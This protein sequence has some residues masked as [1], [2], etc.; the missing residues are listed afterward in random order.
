M[1]IHGADSVSHFHTERAIM[2]IMMLMLLL[3][4]FLLSICTSTATPIPLTIVPTKDPKMLAAELDAIVQKNNQDGIFDGAILVA[5]KCF[6]NPRRSPINLVNC[7]ATPTR[8]STYLERL[9]TIVI[10]H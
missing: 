10:G 6:R 5:Q 7:L 3:A 4:V 8:A 1:V 2:K 9:L